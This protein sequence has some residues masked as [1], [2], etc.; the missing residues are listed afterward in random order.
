MFV[1]SSGDALP[2]DANAK[3]IRVM[4]MKKLEGHPLGMFVRATDFKLNVS[5]EDNHGSFA[6]GKSV[7]MKKTSQKNL[8]CLHEK[9]CDDRMGSG[10]FHKG[11]DKN[12]DDNDAVR[13]FFLRFFRRKKR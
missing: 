10:L 13:Q 5:G 7:A 8:S 2:P 9:V 1:L 12:N 3:R 11:H 6:Q 4:R